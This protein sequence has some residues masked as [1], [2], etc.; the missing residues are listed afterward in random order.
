MKSKLWQYT[1]KTLG[2][3]KAFTIIEVLIT[4]GIFTVISLAM[5]KTLDVT[6]LSSNVTNSLISDADLKMAMY[7]VLEF[8]HC[9]KNL[10]PDNLT[11]VDPNIKTISVLKRYE[12]TADPLNTAGAELIKSGEV[13]K[14][15]LD[16]VKI[17]LVGPDT[18]L[19][20]DFKV[21]YKRNKV[22]H[23]NTKD[24]G[25]CDSTDQ[26]GCY[27]NECNLEY[28]TQTIGAVTNVTTCTVLSCFN[29]NT[30]QFVD[31][32]TV[33]QNEETRP[34][35]N[36]AVKERGRTLVG[37]GGTSD[38]EKS[39][40]VAFGFAAGKSTTG[41]KNTFIGSHAGYE[42]T[43]G[44][45]N[46]FFG[47]HAGYANTTGIYNNFFGTEAGKDNTTG[48][49]NNFFGKS[50]GKNNTTG[51]YNN[52]FGNNTGL[53]NTTGDNNNFFGASA[54]ESN[55]TGN[56]NNFFGNLAGRDNTTGSRNNFFGYRAGLQNTTGYQNNFF[57]YL[58]GRDNTTGSNNNFFGYMAGLQNTT[59]YQNNFFGYYAGYENTTGNF[60]NFFSYGAGKHN[61]TGSSNNFFGTNAGHE[62]TT[63]SGNSFFGTGAG[64]SNTT[65]N[66]NSFIGSG[67]GGSNNTGNNNSFIGNQAGYSNNTGN[68]NSFFGYQAGFSNTT[69]S[70]NII[71]G[72]IAYNSSTLSNQLNI[73]NWLKGDMTT[74]NLKISGKNVCLANS[75]GNGLHCP[76]TLS[77][78]TVTG[79][80]TVGSCT[81]CGTPSSKTL[82]K[83]IKPFK[84]FEKAL[85]NIKN[86]PLFTYQHK[87]EHS[88]K[89][90]MGVIAEELP[91]DLQ[92]NQIPVKPDWPTI[93][94][95]F[96]AAI[97][98]L[99]IKFDRLKKNIF[100]AIEKISERVTQNLKDLRQ[101]NKKIGILQKRDEF[102][103]REIQNLKQMYKQ[104][105][106]LQKINS[107]FRQEIQS[108][109][110]E[111]NLLK[112][113]C[114]IEKQKNTKKSSFFKIKV[115]QIK[116]LKYNVQ[117]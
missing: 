74:D 50:V 89:M 42:N 43:T 7:R 31:C 3:N 71:I 83:N 25:V 53:F 61:T 47:Y 27:I 33:D 99:I 105:D 37:C 76:T 92:L 36:P 103:Q 102:L 4:A 57:G 34:L 46:N 108:L 48:S 26:S 22:K 49:S 75:A 59:G 82:K 54:G 68:N 117:L 91:K 90:R 10:H 9:K 64:G 18:D 55:T 11:V 52:F 106:A 8:G 70:N 73:G 85:E 14:G 81:G 80:L 87:K 88:D 60:N 24:G 93:Y 104:V 109:K 69:G 115:D 44:N 84:N 35:T 13:F 110:I 94:G 72:H 12:D 100:T 67:A 79:N 19:N 77:S 5:F 107:S 2:N 39:S 114:I 15:Y 29:I 40:T 23:L 86:T 20:R 56:Y 30:T 65:G 41:H 112:K 97:K 28:E 6:L 113:N 45:F 78:L 16:I 63:G 38:I 62:N 96:W 21:Y 111:L 66:L 17:E 98:S 101:I 32:Y 51:S 95:T 1:I 58:A 116:K